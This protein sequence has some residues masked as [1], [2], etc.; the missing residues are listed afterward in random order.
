MQKFK[1]GD[2]VRILYNHSGAVANPPLW[3]DFRRMEGDN[4][5]HGTVERVEKDGLVSVKADGGHSQIV[6]ISAITHAHA[7]G[8]RRKATINPKS[9]LGLILDHLLSGKTI[10]RVV[11]ASLY[12]VASLSRRITDLRER[13]YPI[14]VR[15]KQDHT[16]RMYAEY[17]IRTRPVHM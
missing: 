12:R 17:S 11:A 16:G 5:T 14:S 8:G 2:R 1:E 3:W 13:G 15:M 6:P 10:T 4:I 7:E 9:Q